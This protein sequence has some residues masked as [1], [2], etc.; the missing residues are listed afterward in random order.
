MLFWKRYLVIRRLLF[1]VQYCRSTRR[2][3]APSRAGSPQVVGQDKSSK[4]ARG[5][6]NGLSSAPNRELGYA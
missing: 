5:G 6:R 3:G 2:F 1:S 4:D